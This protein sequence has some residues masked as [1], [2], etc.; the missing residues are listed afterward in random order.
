MQN[1]KT[2]QLFMR[3]N[4]LNVGLYRKEIYKPLFL[5]AFIELDGGGGVPISHVQKSPKPRN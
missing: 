4:F 3:I 5:N 2:Y 1:K